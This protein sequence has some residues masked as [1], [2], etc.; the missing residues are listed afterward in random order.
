M[1]ISL[2]RHVVALYHTEEL[3]KTAY[4]S[5]IRY[6]TFNSCISDGLIFPP[7]K[8]AQNMLILFMTH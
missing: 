7:Q 1:Y 8:F 2:R 4:I 5:M 3:T 6:N